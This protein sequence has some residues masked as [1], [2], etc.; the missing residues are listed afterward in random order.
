[1]GLLKKIGRSLK[2][3]LGGGKRS[4]LSAGMAAEAMK[5]GFDPSKIMGGRS[6]ISKNPNGLVNLKKASL[7]P[8]D[9]D[10]SQRDKKTGAIRL[11]AGGIK[12]TPEA[13]A[14][15]KKQ[16]EED[17]KKKPSTPA[18]FKKGGMVKKGR[19]MGIATRGGGA[20]APRKT[21][22]RKGA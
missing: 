6:K 11:G 16:E 4:Q 3:A 14:R 7:T 8:K 1:M 13:I 10:L 12:L 2:R 20:C 21:T 17:G 22:S 9:I 5:G 15:L 18:G 19:G